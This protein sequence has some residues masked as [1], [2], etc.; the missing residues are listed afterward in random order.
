MAKRKSIQVPI[1]LRTK[2]PFTAIVNGVSMVIREP[3]YKREYR[4]D[5]VAED[6]AEL[7]EGAYQ[8]G[9]WHN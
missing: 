6:H 7:D 8:M 2:Y 9:L 1:V 4:P 3:T 5:P